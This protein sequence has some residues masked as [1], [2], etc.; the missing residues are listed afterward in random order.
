MMKNVLVTKTVVT[1]WIVLLIALSSA[2]GLLSPSAANA[3]GRGVLLAQSLTDYNQALSLKPDL[4]IRHG[5]AVLLLA[6]PFVGAPP[7]LAGESPHSAEGLNISEFMRCP[8]P[9]HD[10]VLTL[11]PSGAAQITVIRGMDPRSARTL[12]NYKRLTSVDMGVLSSLLRDA[13]FDRMPD[14]PPN[15]RLSLS[16]H[17][18]LITL[19]IHLDGKAA[20]L[21]YDSDPDTS[22]P[23]KTL[24]SKLHAILDRH[25]WQGTAP[26]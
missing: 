21:R 2:L 7:S 12:I 18:C 17:S 13:G 14:T 15:S 19:E 5:F 10:S 11:E 20:R 4:H 16:K 22:S 3:E 26:K 8:E 6:I 24:A 9:P 23:A 25:D 1:G